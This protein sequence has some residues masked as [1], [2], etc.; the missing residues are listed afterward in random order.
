MIVTS[1]VCPTGNLFSNLNLMKACFSRQQWDMEFHLWGISISTT[2]QNRTS[3]TKKDRP[4]DP[5]AQGTTGVSFK[6]KQI[7]PPYSF[8]LH[9]ILLSVNWN[10]NSA[11]SCTWFLISLS[12]LKVKDNCISMILLC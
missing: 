1:C 4:G 11:L 8:D 10:K 6:D 7:L 12:N 3:R 9:L 2:G 5:S